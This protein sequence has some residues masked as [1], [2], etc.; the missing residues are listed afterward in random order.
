[1]SKYENLLKVLT[2]AHGIPGKVAIEVT[3][4]STVPTDEELD[5]ARALATAVPDYSFF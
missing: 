1:M 2:E 5:A 3:V 4:R